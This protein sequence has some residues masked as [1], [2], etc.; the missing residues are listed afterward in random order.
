MDNIEKIVRNA[1]AN[2]RVEGVVLSDETIR[3][4]N[5]CLKT[6]N[7]S[8]LFQLYLKSNKDLL[9]ESEVLVSSKDSKYC[10]DNGVLKNYLGIKNRDVL[11]FV[12][13]DNAAFYQTQ[14]ISGNDNYKFSFDINSYLNLH[15]K[16]FGAIFPFAGEIRDEKIY[17]SCKPY[18]DLKT[19]FCEPPYIY[20]YLKDLLRK[21]QVK[22]K[23]IKCREDLVKYL[24]YYYGEINMVHPFREGNGRTLRTYFLLLVKELNKYI[25]FGVFDLDYSLWDDDDMSLLEYAT[26][27]NS[28]YGNTDDIYTCFDKVL[29]GRTPEKKRLI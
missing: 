19:T 7:S 9:E 23:E 14:I 8:F 2:A 11:D 1:D 6:D 24:A 18:F 4:I 16:L 28:I 22:I 3:M 25:S 29:V 17:K 10:Y 15:R 26:I 20:E 12:A 21:M 5:D 27:V 13:S